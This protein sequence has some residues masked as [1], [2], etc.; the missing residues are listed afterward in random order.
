MKLIDRRNGQVVDVPEGEVAKL[1]QTGM[2]AL[3]KG[4]TLPVAL[5]SGAVGTVAAGDAMQALAGNATI[6]SEQEFRQAQQ[7]ERYGGAG[8][9]LEAAGVG[10]LRGAGMAFGLP[11]D[12]LA[13]D[14][15]KAFGSYEEEN[16][17]YRGPGMVSPGARMRDVLGG[18][19]SAHPYAS[20]GGELAGVIGAG[21]LT[22]GETALG[23]VGHAAEE[24]LPAAAGRI[25]RGAVRGLAEGAPMG[26]I[27][28]I[29]EAALGD[30]DIT[31][32]K[33]VAGMGHGAFMGAG[34]GASFSG[35]GVAKDAARNQLGRWV[36]KLAPGDVEALAVKQFGHVPDGLGEKVQKAYS[37]ASASVAGKDAGVIEDFTSGA[38]DPAS[39]SY[40]RRHTA[41]FDAPAIQ[42]A[43]QRDVRTHVDEMLRSGDLVSAEARGQLKA[44]HVDRAVKKGNEADTLAHTNEQLDRIIA[45]ADYQLQHAEG[46]APTMKKALAS[47]KELAS[48]ARAAANGEEV[49]GFKVGFIDPDAGLE[50]GFATQKPFSIGDEMRPMVM[51]GG[52][53]AD[54]IAI[55]DPAM[56][57][58][59][60]SRP[61]A[62]A[63][64]DAR[65]NAALEAELADIF[66]DAWVG[67]REAP[68]FG[69]A[70]RDVK[71]DPDAGLEGDFPTEDAFRWSA[72]KKVPRAVETNIT[73]AETVSTGK[74][75][76][77]GVDP[78]RE[79]IKDNGKLFVELDN[80]K[81][82][83][84]RV[85]KT[86]TNSVRNIADPLDMMNA[87]RSLDWF[88]GAA[89]DIRN[90][91]EDESLWGKA[92]TDQRAI[93][94]AWTK[95]LDASQRF[96]KAL[97]TET[98]RDPTD[99]YRR[100]RGADP[101][102]VES[103]VKNLTNPNND[104]THTAVKD[105]VASTRELA[106][107][108]SKSYDLPAEK[109]A[110]VVRVR[111]A[112]EGFEKTI[113]K[114]ESALVTANQ[115]R[116][117]TEGANDSMSTLLGTVGGIFGGLPG[118]IIGAAAGAVAN[119]GRVVAQLAAVE[120]LMLKVDTRISSNVR[121]FFKGAGKAPPAVPEAAS[122][123]G[124]DETV[125]LLSRAVDVDGNITPAGR[126]SIAEA[127][128][129]LGE[130]APN[131]AIA[132]GM[133]AMEI[134][135][136]LAGKVPPA[137]RNPYEMFPGDEPP[138][139]SDT[140][141]ETFARYVHA[142]QDPM[143]VVD[144]LARGDVTPE[145]ADVLQTCYPRL[146]GQVRAQIDAQV[147][148]GQAAG[149]PIDYE[150]RVAYGVLF[151]T[152]TDATMDPEVLMIIADAQAQRKG[153]FQA[154]SKMKPGR[155]RGAPAFAPRFQTSFEAA[156][157]RRKGGMF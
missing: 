82:A 153:G 142:A 117:L 141:R 79:V 41:V 1:A 8:A 143:S 145:E 15:A 119:P 154:G 63:R 26:A 51:K 14:A 7:A 88:K 71:I 45:G 127:I 101:A 95:Q 78:V 16:D 146:Y 87:Q 61:H 121:R 97:T 131:I 38:F 30:T 149:K 125:K 32:E 130:G 44:E 96:H 106:G 137:M 144:R 33:V 114:A 52:G 89:N 135:T 56:G 53:R 18:L 152:R 57:I 109:I 17:P 64:A 13:V 12:E 37:K 3:P 48:R 147:R 155:L 93:N 58:G 31:A 123:K 98:G 150:Q 104:L 66:G 81:R 5:E 99:P 73:D 50:G 62:L 126:S 84:Q 76:P 46:V 25:A 34:L 19:Q 27:G 69:R 90:G 134:A 24:L 138:L 108:I 129:D 156:S 6:P 67:P 148:A 28:A 49:V 54:R 36:G 68:R 59:N 133:K 85:S 120:R 70:T 140:E 128:G 80:L 113:G 105:F 23:S 136:Y 20:L 77:I 157:S 115:Y 124:F 72:A 42:E 65:G 118:G 91:L 83:L 100:L 11:S 102:R 112:A 151:K 110:E 86:G 47:V 21:A 55:E 10:A 22:G 60:V 94:A 9:G 132:V 29:N 107:A 116:A 40:Q 2:F 103:Y 43:A 111:T 35:L 39:P 4:A 139:V 74:K 92:A 75:K 122:E